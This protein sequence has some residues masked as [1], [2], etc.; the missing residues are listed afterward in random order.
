MFTLHQLCQTLV[1][2]KGSDL[3]LIA[4]SP[5]RI[6]IDGS[7]LSL[8]GQSFS[9]SDIQRLISEMFDGG[10]FP[11][12]SR[13]PN[14]DTSFSLEGIGRFRCHLYSQRGTP[15]IALRF[16]PIEIPSVRELGLPSVIGELVR[17]P[18]G[19]VFI[20]GPSGSGKSTTLAALIDLIN[21]ERRGHIV[22]IED[23]VEFLHGHK[24]SIVTS[25]RNREGTLRIFSQPSQELCAKI[26]MSYA[27]VK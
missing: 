19:L 11:L 6:R 17:K 13:V 23:P 1:E 5:P 3:H 9:P 18:Q 26:L 14:R 25:A 10:D 15:A 4:G 22:T 2:R 12:D 20:T 7:L 21:Q 27:S 8:S 24:S 16:V